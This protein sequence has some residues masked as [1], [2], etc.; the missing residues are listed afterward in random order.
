MKS[1]KTKKGTHKKISK[2]SKD[3]PGDE[4]SQEGQSVQQDEAAQHAML[5][6]L[7]S[8][9]EDEFNTKFEKMLVGCIF[10]CSFLNC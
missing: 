10:V 3:P 5:Q 8:L 6:N 4:H 7:K 2:H 9:P 1:K